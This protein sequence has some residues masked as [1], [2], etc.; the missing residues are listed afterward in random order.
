LRPNLGGLAS[1][2]GW[3]LDLLFAESTGN[4]QQISRASVVPSGLSKSN[5]MIL[6]DESCPVGF[7]SRALLEIL[8]A[9]SAASFPHQT[10]AA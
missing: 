6:L 9:K 1:I 4:Q 7:A 5:H 2:S 10:A 3:V 8:Q